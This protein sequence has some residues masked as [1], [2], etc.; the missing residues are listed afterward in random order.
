M[1]NNNNGV[2]DLNMILKARVVELKV[3]LDAKGSNLPSQVNAI[4]KWLDDT[5]RRVKL[6]VNLNYTQS[7]LSKQVGL[8]NKFLENKNVNLNVKL[9]ASQAS[10]NS[11]L[12]TLTEMIDDRAVNLKV[13]LDTKGSGITAQLNELNKSLAEKH[14]NLKVKLQGT[15]TEMNQQISSIKTVLENSKT[16]KPMKIKVNI[17]VDGSAK[18]IQKQLKEV[19]DT[20]DQFNKRYA[21]QL[22]EMQK[23][24]FKPQST[25]NVGGAG[26]NV[27]SGTASVENFNNMKQYTN[28]LRE[29][30]RILKSKLPAGQNG[31]FSSFQMKDAKGNLTSFVAALERADGVVEKVRYSWNKDKE[32]FQVMDRTT[33]TQTEKLMF[34][35]MQALKDLSIEMD[36]TGVSSNKLRK[37]YN[38]LMEEADKGTL[39]A[40]SVKDFERQIKNHNQSITNAKKYNQEIVKQRKLIEDVI[41]ARDEEW[42]KTQDIDKR[43]QFNAL[44]DGVKRNPQ[45]LKEQQL[46]LTMLTSEANKQAKAQ[47][48]INET[49]K[50]RLRVLQQVR[51]IESKTI[52]SDRTSQNLIGEIKLMAQR[53]KSAQDW[54]DITNKMN[55]LKQS[56]AN[57]AQMQKSIDI[58]IKLEKRLRELADLGVISSDQLG[59]ALAQ[60]PLTASRGFADL[61]RQLK[62]VDRRLASTRDEMKK[63]AD[64]TKVLFEGNTGNSAIIKDLI[65]KGDIAELEKFIGSLYKGQVEQVRL[66]DTTDKLGRAVTQLQ[67]RMKGS[68]KQI[69][70]YTLQMESANGALRQVASGLDYNANRNLGVFEQL[71]IAMARVPV[72][73][74]AMTAFYGTINSVRAMTQEL[75]KLDTA[76]TEI[77]RVAS[78]SINIDTLFEGGVQLS[79]ELGNNVHDVMAAIADFSRTFG[80]FNERQILAITETA[81][82]MSNVS[83]LKADEATQSLVGTMNAF[84]IEAAESIRIVDAL[85]EVKC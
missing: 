71:R 32:Q 74:T 50:Q 79:K 9:A 37:E 64:Q 38:R 19:Y 30:E 11:Q 81:T 40:E 1:A 70:T 35:Q 69:Q 53:A 24:A 85:N 33:A 49:T 15:V 66:K 21:R 84:N 22:N 6:K 63:T 78:D 18:E 20:V 31:L 55:K 44:L 12:K 26:T 41:R 8:I 59:R 25:P 27:P 29:A 43:K 83:D 51:A 34:K 42:K 75:I 2:N 39:S 10:M 5:D 23:Q 46:E 3:K 72:W 77:R 56:N 45:Y 17:D 57:D 48:E 58:Q 80:D 47:K 4:S 36:K 73:M 7:G 52:S 62:V 28:A 14:V 13:N 54:L 60:I 61:E 68:G 82:L 16:F 76:L 65:K 67:V